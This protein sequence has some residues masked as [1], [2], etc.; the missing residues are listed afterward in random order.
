MLVVE[1]DFNVGLRGRAWNG[2]DFG[3][4]WFAVVSNLCEARSPCGGWL[5]QPVA[6]G[7]GAAWR[8][9]RFAWANGDRVGCCVFTHY[10]DRLAERNADSFA[11]A[12]GE[13]LM[14]WMLAKNLPG[15]VNN[16]AG[17]HRFRR[18]TRN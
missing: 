8:K 17:S 4:D 18:A 16:H 2:S 13:M 5:D 15:E 11:L 10:V 12:D 1:A 14:A 7:S 6:I 9:E 3:G